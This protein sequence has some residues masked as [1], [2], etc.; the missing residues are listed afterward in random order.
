VSRRWVTRALALVGV[1]LVL[2]LAPASPA[3]AHGAHAPTATN[4]HTQ[5]TGITPALEG[6]TVQA[7]EAGTGLQLTNHS[8][9]TVQVLGYDGEPYLEV[10]PDGAYQNLNS[11]ATYLNEDITGAARVPGH[12]DPEAAPAW[13]RINRAPVARWYDHRAHWMASSLP[14]QVV[15]DPA[16]RTRV[17]EWS[18][19]LRA[20]GQDFQLAGT[21]DWVPPPSPWP[22][23]AVAALGAAMVGAL[24]LAAYHRPAQVV[25]AAVAAGAGAVAVSY[26]VAREVDAG[27]TSVGEVLVWLATG[28]LWQVLAGLAA[29]AAGAYQLI[30]TRSGQPSEPAA[31]ALAVAG[32]C[33]AIFAGFTDVA[34]FARALPPVPFDP[35]LARLM[36]LVVLA[37]GVGATA[38][39]ALA[40]R[41]LRV[42]AEV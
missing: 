3:L 18:V 26:A 14:P 28:L 37:G 15:D 10:R 38:A 34:V 21:L 12:A 27:A 23:W 31:F 33:L 40:L 17:L 8:S 24:G 35:T 2:L 19:P 41:R 22:W 42:R 16:T 7:I 36:V 6:V 25:T 20:D 30:A 5:I 11:P 4:Y 29:I 39:G 32:A 1:G 9:R 13:Q